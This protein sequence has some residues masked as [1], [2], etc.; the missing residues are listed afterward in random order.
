MTRRAAAM[1]CAAAGSGIARGGV[2]VTASK[3]GLSGTLCYDPCGF[4]GIQPARPRS[5]QVD[6]RSTMDWWHRNRVGA[7]GA[8]LALFLLLAT[9]TAVT[10]S[11]WCDEGWFASPGWNLA[12]RGFMGTTVLDPASGTPH[13]NTR[14]RLDGIDRYTY[15]VMPLNL[16]IQAGWYKLA[17]FSLLRM[18][19]LSIIWAVLALAGWTIVFQEITGSRD[20][21]LL[22]VALVS[23]DY[24]FIWAAAD[25]RMDMLCSLLGVASLAAYL[26]LRQ[27]SLGWALFAANGL[28]A[29]SALAH[30]NGNLYLVV[31]T[32][33]V[34]L[35]DRRRLE[36]RYLIAAGIPYLLAAAAWAPYVMKAPEF[37]RI[38]LLGNA[39]GRQR[40]FA[41]PIVSL[42]RE[43]DRYRFAFGFA[44]W[45]HGFA[46]VSILE[47]A[48][49]LAGIGACAFYRPLRRN[50]GSRTTIAVIA[51]LCLFMW[52]FEGLKSSNYLL[53]VIPWFSLALAIAAADYW[54][55]RRGPRLAPA[56]V[57]GAVLFLAVVRIAAP[58]LKD[59]YHRQYLPAARY[60][61]QNTSPADLIMGPA[62]LGFHL[63]FDRNILDDYLEGTTTGKSAAFIV[64]D[65]RHSDYLQAIRITDVPAYDRVTRLLAARYDKV[66][67]QASY[68]I[69][70][71]R[72]E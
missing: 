62:E 47:L 70:R 12:F 49:F 16:V 63:G 71:K 14:T 2:E 9:W 7:I 39:A 52:L 6:R 56:A 67:D 57:V 36:W 29:A 11:P 37:F 27:R 55:E 19:A 59:N 3:S 66:Y 72:A 22:G 28:L 58:A 15:W 32:C 61:A 34:V 23:T 51:A 35:Y 46:H 45:S 48:G 8:I 40:A 69:Y 25:G 65:A 30:P 10:K 60:L 5:R 64:L 42:G 31:L 38:Q 68:Q 4:C 1:G 53:H 43:I 13:L 21:A 18:R 44:P 20:T 33:L 41:E 26:R 24:Y 50:P 17:G 54:L